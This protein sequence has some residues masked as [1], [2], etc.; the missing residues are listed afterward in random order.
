MHV[1]FCTFYF[2]S[3]RR[4]IVFRVGRG[5]LSGVSDAEA[6]FS[7]YDPLRLDCVQISRVSDS[8][9]T[10]DQEKKRVSCISPR[11]RDH[12]VFMCFSCDLVRFCMVVGLTHCWNFLRRVLLVRS[13][14][15]VCCYGTSTR[16]AT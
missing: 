5:G 13:I 8:K 15:G 9:S 10:E 6:R 3:K 16:R 1:V 7:G 12:I 4:N 14:R 11:G 2:A